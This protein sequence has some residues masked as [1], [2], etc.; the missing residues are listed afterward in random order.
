MIVLI[1]MSGGMLILRLVSTTDVATGATEPQMQPLIPNRQTFLA[2]SCILV[3]S[4]WHGE[5]DRYASKQASS[6]PPQKTVFSFQFSVFS[7]SDNH[8]HL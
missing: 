4:E 5:S 7:F 3:T 8:F 6:I 2:F 1:K